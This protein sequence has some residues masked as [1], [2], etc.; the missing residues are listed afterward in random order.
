MVCI[1]VHGAW[2]AWAELS[3]IYIWY[4]KEKNKRRKGK[5]RKERKGEERKA[6]REKVM[7]D[8]C[9]MHARIS[10]RMEMGYGRGSFF[11]GKNNQYLYPIL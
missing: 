7:Y 11:T 10:L 1:I 4:R 9:S 3:G 2:Y 5:E 6:S 8:P